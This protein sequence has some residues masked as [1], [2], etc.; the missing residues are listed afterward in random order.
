[1]S[2]ESS[3]VPEPKF[4]FRSLKAEAEVGEMGLEE[5]VERSGLEK[6]F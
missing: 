6:C 1:M 4:W 5:G 3:G 2:D